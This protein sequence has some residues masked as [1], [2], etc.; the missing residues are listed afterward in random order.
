MAL[1][2][3]VKRPPSMRI[4]TWDLEWHPGS[5]EITIAGLYDGKAYRAFRDI[6]GFLEHIL[7][8]RYKGAYLFAH[9]GGRFDGVFLLR[10]LRRYFPHLP[11]YVIMNGSSAVMIEVRCDGYPIR[12]CDS[13]FLFKQSLEDMGESLGMEKGECPFYPPPLTTKQWLELRTYNEQDCRIL[14]HGLDRAAHALESLG[15]TLSF[16]LASTALRL[17]RVRYLSEDIPTSSVHNREI[18]PGYIA[19]RVED[20]RRVSMWGKHYDINSSFP[21]SQMSPLPG[22]HLTTDRTIGDMTIAHVRVRVPERWLPPLPVR[23]GNSIYFPTGE[24]DAWYCTDDLILLEEMGG[25]VLEVYRAHHYEPW[26]DISEFVRD[27]YNL[28]LK[29]A[30]D[31]FLSNFWKIT[32]NAG[33]YGKLGERGDKEKIV[34]GL[35]RLKCPHNGEHEQIPGRPTCIRRVANGVWAILEPGD[36]KHTHIPVPLVTT[37]RSRARITRFASRAEGLAYCDTDGISSQSTFES[38]TALGELKLE[39]EYVDGIFPR[40]KMYSVTRTT[41]IKDR[42]RVKMAKWL[43]KRGINDVDQEQEVRHLVKAKGFPR[44]LRREFEYLVGTDPTIG[45]GSISA[46][47]FDSLRKTMVRSGH[48]PA[49]GMIAKGLYRVCGECDTPTGG[50]PCEDHPDSPLLAAHASRPKRESLGDSDSRPWRFDELSEP[51][52][53]SGISYGR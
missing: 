35:K 25:A 13:Q 32:M 1:T 46:R 19:S 48:E 6:R 52:T 44:L 4:L 34:L 8:R 10:E 23:H 53:P 45:A 27:I 7:G 18:R 21:H 16:T 30:D 28:R 41:P 42:E 49:E 51:W 20:Y 12:F 3:I 47:Q 33:V 38:S 43:K 36:P 50:D 11:L 24:F 31:P 14:W 39:Y 26:N 29:A 15:S 22:R 2:R 37:A 40:C 9:F 17:F 5:L